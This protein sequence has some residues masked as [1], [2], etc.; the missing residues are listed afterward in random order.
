MIAC[1]SWLQMSN[2]G[3]LL[4]LVTDMFNLGKVEGAYYFGISC[5]DSS[6]KIIEAYFSKSE[7]SP[8]LELIPF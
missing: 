2:K 7:L 1:F 5:M 3:V 8:F 6:S 4:T